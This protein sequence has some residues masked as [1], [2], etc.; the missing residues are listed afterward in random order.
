VAY[1]AEA[2]AAAVALLEQAPAPSLSAPASA[3]G[4]QI[5]ELAQVVL[6][7]EGISGLYKGFFSDTDAVTEL[8]EGLGPWLESPVDV[9]IRY[10]AEDSVGDI[11]IKLR[12]GQLRQ[13]VL[14]DGDTIDLQG[15]TPITSALATYR[16]SI[17]SRFDFRVESFRVSLE[18]YR[19]A[20]VC[21]LMLAGAPPPDGRLISPCVLINGEGVCGQPTQ[22]GV[23][24]PTPSAVALAACLDR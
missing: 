10:N 3:E 7:W 24:F 22:A 11:L 15:L 20:R 19:G 13:P 9:T 23:I 17:A 2:E 14:V 4:A 21:Q 8:A 12:P 16:S 1:A 6:V 5:A 18:S